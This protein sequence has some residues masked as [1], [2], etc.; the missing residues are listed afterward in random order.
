VISAALISEG[1]IETLPAGEVTADQLR[2][3]DLL[4]VGSPTRSFR[5]TPAV[6]Q[7]LKTFRKIISPE[8]R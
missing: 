3:P 1:N 8:F 7:F 6:S 2:E 5:P 4:I